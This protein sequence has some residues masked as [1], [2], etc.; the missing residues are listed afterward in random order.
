MGGT[1]T[2]SQT[3]SSQTNPYS[4]ASTGLNGI[5]S[6]V[7]N[8]VPAAGTLTPG[9]SGAINQV[10][11][12]SSGQPNYAPAIGSGTFG[13]LN[14]G[15]ANDNNAAITQNLGNYQGL[16]AKTASGGNIGA[17]SAL[18]PQLD[19]IASDVTNQTNGQWAAAGRD[20]SPGNAQAL[21]RGIA[22]GEA[23]VIA[24]QYNT[25]VSNQL[26]AANSLYG[27]ANTTFGMLNNNT[28]AANQNFTNG[29]GNVT[30]GLNAENAAP[31]AALNA[32]SQNFNIPAS[33]YQT[34]LGM[35][36]PVAAQFST[37]NGQSN[38]TSTMSGAQQFSTIM[39]GLGT[40]MPKAN[41]NFAA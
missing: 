5:L 23:P 32:A 30:A 15:G 33:Q 39:Q 9:Q 12:N 24:G 2:T 18:Q 40:L 8:M 41:I 11:S 31:T 34:L 13:L 1:S 28:A 6:G 25:D 37:Q 26:A 3:Q 36:S 17:N 22:Q 38:G 14:G 10:I 19:T 35:L 29:V 27:A 21:A 16:L 7:T 20:G 4:P